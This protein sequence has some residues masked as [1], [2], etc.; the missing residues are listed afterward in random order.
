MDLLCTHLT[1]TLGISYSELVLQF[2]SNIVLEC[3]SAFVVRCSILSVLHLVEFVCLGCFLA[4]LGNSLLSF[5]VSS[6]RLV[7]KSVSTQTGTNFSHSNLFLQGIHM[8]IEL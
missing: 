2:Y 1:F 3:G 5:L 4:P 7:L 8:P 6:L